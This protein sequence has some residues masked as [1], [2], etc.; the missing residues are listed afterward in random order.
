MRYNKILKAKFVSRPNR[1]IA[2]V[3][4]NGEDVV[5]YVKNTGRCKELLVSGCDIYLAEST[6]FQRK[7][8]YDLV[9]TDKNGKLFNI[10]SYAPNIAA[11]EYLKKYIP[12]L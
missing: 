1:F 2:Y 8:K 10:D 4:L 5:C 9:A 11:G 3:Q 12:L 6:N 7:T